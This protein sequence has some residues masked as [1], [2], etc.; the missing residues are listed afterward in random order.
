MELEQELKQQLQ[1]EQGQPRVGLLLT[2]EE[3]GA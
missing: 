1:A 2:E 3:L